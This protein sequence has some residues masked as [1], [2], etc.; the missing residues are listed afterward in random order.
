MYFCFFNKFL[1]AFCFKYVYKYG[2]LKKG[3]KMRKFILTL[4]DGINEL[5]LGIPDDEV[6]PWDKYHCSDI[7]SEDIQ[8]I[9]MLTWDWPNKALLFEILQKGLKIHIWRSKN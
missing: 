6:I 1:V 9:K 7:S 3:N 8:L 4:S 5:P 2:I